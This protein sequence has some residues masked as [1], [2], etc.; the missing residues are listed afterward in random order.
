MRPI[1]HDIASITGPPLI[2][3][4]LVWFLYGITVMQVYAY[5]QCFPEDNVKIKSLDT[6]QSVLVAA[7]AFHWF[8]NGFGNMGI[9]F[10]PFMSPFDTPILDGIIAFAEQTF[11]CWRLRVLHKSWWL[12][13]M[14]FFVAVVSLAGG[15][16]SGVGGYRLADL[17]RLDT[18]K[19]QICLWLGGSALTDTLIAVVMTVLLLRSRRGEFQ[20]TD[21]I[22]T[23]IVR[24]TVETNAVTASVAIIAVV[25]PLAIP[26]VPTIV[27]APTYA[28]GKL[29]S[30]TLL[31]V[32]NN[33]IYMSSSGISPQRHT[34][35]STGIEVNLRQTPSESPRGQVTET[36]QNK[37]A[38]PYRI[39]VFREVEITKDI[40]PQNNIKH[41]YEM[42]ANSNS[43]GTTA[44][45]ASQTTRKTSNGAPG[46]TTRSAARGL[47]PKVQTAEG[48]RAWLLE[49]GALASED[50]PM[51]LDGLRKALVTLYTRKDIPQDVK[52]GMKAIAIGLEEVKVEE[53]GKMV[54]EKVGK[55]M[56]EYREAL[57][58]LAEATVKTITEMAEQTKE[59]VER[60]EE[61]QVVDMR[62]E[63][64][65]T[66]EARTGG[67]EGEEEA[68]RNHTVSYAQA[69]R[70]A[71][72]EDVERRAKDRT[73]QLI[74]D[75]TEG[76]RGWKDL[77]EKE[78]IE[79]AKV[80]K[81]LMGIQG[82]D[83]PE[84]EFLSA[85]K[86]RNGGVLYKL[87]STDAAKWLAKPDVRRTFLSRFGAGATVSATIQ[88][89][90]WGQSRA[91][92]GST[93][94]SNNGHGKG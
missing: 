58:T 80:A 78:L 25:C 72:R 77:T 57:E 60:V 16:A 4:M 26:H 44:K 69:A 51:S 82:M 48:A 52:D 32:L 30:N 6:T 31:A 43:G 28:L 75:N 33:R 64:S 2:G 67:D 88:Q 24:L 91:E 62:R 47:Q 92:M 79:K 17:G 90:T 8:A 12:P 39:Q 11:F 89:N 74:V 55:A 15:I 18:L 3:V 94:G 23:R 50:K 5:Y 63:E 41:V 21:N 36:R 54:M 84:I 56:D 49:N 27:M 35:L 66:K 42:P 13:S 81:E 29:Y 65:T 38:G 40:S 68:P 61:G 86:L 83:S 85:R 10:E 20:Y 46:A 19:W 7:D 87:N 93:L 9:L 76:G 59:L 14:V 73:R 37:R 70:R 22:L 71:E 34:F 53:T 45:E 1:P